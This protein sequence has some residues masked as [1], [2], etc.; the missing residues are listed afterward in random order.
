LLQIILSGQL[1]L[2]DKLAHPG[3]A[4]LRQRLSSIARLQ[5]FGTEETVLYI[6]HRLRVAG[7]K[8]DVTSLFD[9]PAL[10]RIV[11]LSGGIPRIIN[12]VCFNALSLGFAIGARQIDSSIIEEVASDLG[13]GDSLK[14]AST[15]LSEIECMIPVI[16][17]PPEE[18]S[19]YEDRPIQE[20]CAEVST[21]PETAESQAPASVSAEVH[22]NPSTDDGVVARIV[23]AEVQSDTVA[24]TLAQACLSAEPEGKGKEEVAKTATIPA[25]VAPLLIAA[26]P[27]APRVRTQLRRSRNRFRPR[28]LGKLS[29]DRTRAAVALAILLAIGIL[30]Y[31]E[32]RGSVRR[33]EAKSTAQMAGRLHSP[34]NIST[35]ATRKLELAR[36]QG[37]G[38]DLNAAPFGGT[39][40]RTTAFTTA[41]S[42]HQRHAAEIRVNDLQEKLVAL[43]QSRVPDN[44]L[45]TQTEVPAAAPFTITDTPI[46]LTSIVSH[47]LNLPILKDKPSAL[48]ISAPAVR[49]ESSSTS[50]YV[51]PRAISRPPPIYPDFAK[52]SRLQGD[53]MLLV[54]ISSTGAVRNAKVLSGN[55]FL[56][57]AAENAALHWSYAPG[58]INGVASESQM[59]IV[60]RFR[61]Q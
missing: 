11:V 32:H 8:G 24:A 36:P 26:N 56:A 9:R 38:T 49:M 46:A 3:L 52:A 1:E 17:H 28:A 47:S 27:P 41:S 61:L 14:P 59:Q 31:I 34:E 33:V 42:N 15:L 7:H 21:E 54:S 58:L 44:V 22:S 12:N 6:D 43:S 18:P 40:Q 57:T 4:Q 5:K 50:S 35:T 37:A 13:I 10:A 30:A 19:K 16:G 39:R 53:V 45:Q 23:E 51:P 29:I 60:V 25:P 20:V 55:T 2:E 48:V